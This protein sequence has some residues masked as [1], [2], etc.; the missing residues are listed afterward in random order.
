VVLRIEIVAHE[1]K[2]S[3]REGEKE[4]A[5]RKFGVDNDLAKKLL[6]EIDALLAEA[7]MQPSDVERVEQVCREAGFTTERI[8]QSVANAYGFALSRRDA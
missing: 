8:A 5:A 4:L 6:P 1:G 2:V 7:G 3:L